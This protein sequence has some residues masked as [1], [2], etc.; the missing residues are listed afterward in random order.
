MYIPITGF[1]CIVA[2]ICINSFKYR[3]EM[4]NILLLVIPCMIHQFDSIYTA[5]HHG[6]DE[7]KELFNNHHC[8]DMVIPNGFAIYSSQFS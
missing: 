6:E 2:T 1:Y 7:G 8:W 4:K 3:I 5:E